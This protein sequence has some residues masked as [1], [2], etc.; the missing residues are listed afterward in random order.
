MNITKWRMAHFD[1]KYGSTDAEIWHLLDNPD[2]IIASGSIILQVTHLAL[3][4]EL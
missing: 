1:P 2:L 4:I 3:Q